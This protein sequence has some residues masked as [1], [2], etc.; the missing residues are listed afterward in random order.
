[1][2]GDRLQGSAFSGRLAR[3]GPAALEAA[4]KSGAPTG[5]FDAI[6]LPGV[7][8]TVSSRSG[9]RRI[10]ATLRADLRL[11]P[12]AAPSPASLALDAL[13]VQ[14][15]IENPG[16]QPL[17]VQARG[18]LQASPE[19]ADWTLAGDL[20]GAAFNTD[21][22][23]NLAGAVPRIT[24]Q[25]RFDTLDLNRL[26]DSGPAT[27]ASA[28]AAPAP[29]GGT[30]VD[31]S[32]L[33]SVDGRFS[34]QAGSLAYQ[35]YRVAAARIDATLD[36]GVLQVSALQGRI[37]GGSVDASAR[38]E[39]ANGRVAMK[40]TASGIDIAAALR[41]VADKQWMDG[42]GRVTM[43]IDATGRTVEELKSK[44]HGRLALQLRDGAINGI[45]L[46]KTLRTAKAA[47]TQRTDAVQK[48]NETEK[49]DFSELSA[50]FQIADG[51]ARSNDL[52][53]KSPFLRLGGEGAV[54]IGRGRIDYL[55]RATVTGT[56]KGQ[57]GADLEA[58]K[59]LQVPVR[60]SGPFESLDWKVEWSSVLAG[61]LTQTLKNQVQDR[62]E[63]KLGLKPATPT[64]P[65][66]PKQKPKDAL[67][68]VFKGLLK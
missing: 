47:I 67:K 40:G 8:A 63:E 61:A 41:D 48:A 43:D 35:R 44:L 3:G 52:D 29:A 60:L 32:G 39:A 62:L 2:T 7:E 20:N 4:F 23:A 27:A 65:N 9:A 1:M 53:V 45:N 46:A 36:G 28:P 38:A 33:R 54:D 68:D 37:W 49:T 15:Q 51:V 19:R 11:K 30:P 59:G 64:D 12:P 5:G 13:T 14:G 57:D 42:T 31:L 24:A 18:K 55:A 26:L 34:L 22:Q 21:G 6:A 10:D 16:L 50:S 25:A 66:A 56:S 17:K 58:L